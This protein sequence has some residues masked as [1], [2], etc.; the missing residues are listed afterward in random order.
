MKFVSYL[1]ISLC[2]FTIGH[3]Q[4]AMEPLADVKVV[5]GYVKVKA[6]QN[7]NFFVY[8]EEYTP[9]EN[10]NRQTILLIP[11][12]SKTTKYFDDFILKTQLLEQGYR[13]VVVDPMLRGKTLKKNFPIQNVNGEFKFEVTKRYEVL[14][15]NDPSAEREAEYLLQFLINKKY[16]N[17][18]ILGHSRGAYI[19]A[20]LSHYV[21]KRSLI[22]LN[23]FIDMNGFVS[24]TNGAKPYSSDLTLNPAETAEQYIKVNEWL[25]NS[26]DSVFEDD[27]SEIR[28]KI[29]NQLPLT[30]DEI[31]RLSKVAGK[32][33][34]VFMLAYDYGALLPFETSFV[35]HLYQDAKE[36]A[37]RLENTSKLVSLPFQRVWADRERIAFESMMRAQRTIVHDASNIFGGSN[38]YVIPRSS[39]AY[40]NKI[41]A[42]VLSISGDKDQIVDSNLSKLKL[43]TAANV[44]LDVIP[45][46]GHYGPEYKES[47]NRLRDFFQ[48]NSNKFRMGPLSCRYSSSRPR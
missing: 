17:L 25:Y 43:H 22:K 34:P 4:E 29:L 7:K 27:L 39:L 47:T 32:I 33:M 14:G 19:G 18:S 6:P 31:A 24:Y 35:T 9:K 15:F 11:G 10:F 12:Y 42:P 8:H 26:N 1:I 21:E 40:I 45:N 16:K 20:A 30:R 38:T 28:K 23:S 41:E 2:V 13:V 44:S 46:E 48:K 5:N 36:N 37:P 3:A